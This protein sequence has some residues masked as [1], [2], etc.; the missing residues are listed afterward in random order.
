MALGSQG[1]VVTPEVASSSLV[2]LATFIRGALPL[3]LP[4]T[5]ARSALRRLASH[6]WAATGYT[7]HM[8]ADMDRR[9][10]LTGLLSAAAVAGGIDVGAQ[11]P[12][13]PPDPS[14]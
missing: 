12:A 13:G 8:S 1:S 11:A 14:L 3:G 4:R 6:T 5:V 7:S 2:G 9:A 10:L